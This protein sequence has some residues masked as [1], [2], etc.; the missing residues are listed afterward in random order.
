MTL[1]PVISSPAID[2]P[3]GFSVA[4]D[5]GEHCRKTRTVLHSHFKS[6]YFKITTPPVHWC[7]ERKHDSLGF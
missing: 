1:R 5:E 3:T 6:R 7:D 2:D 4:V